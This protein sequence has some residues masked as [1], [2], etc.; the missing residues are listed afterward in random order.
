MADGNV[1][2]GVMRT[3]LQFA[4]DAQSFAASAANGGFAVSDEGGQAMVRAIEDFQDWLLDARTDI[5]HLKL[6]P[7]LGGSPAAIKAAEH[8]ALV[9]SGDERS[10]EHVLVQ[11]GP[12]LEDAKNGIKQ[13]MANLQHADDQGQQQ[14]RGAGNS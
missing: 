13:A 6:P 2:Q 10:F 8:T 9:A 3:A 5:N 14:I 4:N 12:I 1:W 11:L 7:K